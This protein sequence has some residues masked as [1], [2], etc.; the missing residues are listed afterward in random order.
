[1]L[2]YGSGTTPAESTRDHDNNLRKLLD[3]TR[4]N[5]LK[6]NKKKLKL[7][8]SEVR[9]MGHLLTSTG[10]WV[11]PMKVKAIAEMPRPIANNKKMV[12]H[13][14]G[15]VQYLSQFLPKLYMQMWQSH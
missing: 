7:H 4:E 2:V 10:V 8:L 3:H 14:L 11:D 13:L 12:E 15:T 5:N 6:L 1:M 9:H